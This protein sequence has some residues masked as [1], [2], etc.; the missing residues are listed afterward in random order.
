MTDQVERGPSVTSRALSVLAAFEDSSGSL[1]AAVIAERSGLPLSTTYRLIGELEEWGGLRRGPDGRYQIGMRIWEIGQ[2]AGRR[3]RDRAHPH[4]QDL[5]ELTREN[6][7]LAIRDGVQ[8]IYVD[9]V[10]GSRR[11]SVVSRVGGRVPLHAS[12]VGRV[13]LAFE[14]DWYITAY[15]KRDLEAPSP[16][17]VTDRRMLAQLIAE[18]KA[19]RISVT[20][21]QLRPGALSIAAPIEFSGEVVAAVGLV[22]ESNRYRE[23]SRFLPLLKG[24]AERIET[25]MVGVPMRLGMRSPRS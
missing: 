6:V 5:F 10:Y 3:L 12:A 17:T 13:L 8:A 15:L 7:H 11:L 21:E 23:V 25:A 18:V 19:T 16:N 1:S 2:L 14:P 24:T 9:K 4:L 22:F 20:I